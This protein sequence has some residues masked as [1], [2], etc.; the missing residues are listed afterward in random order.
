MNSHRESN[1]RSVALMLLL[2]SSMMHRT[3]AIEIHSNEILLFT[4]EFTPLLIVDAQFFPSPNKT[5]NLC[6]RIKK[7]VR[8]FIIVYVVWNTKSAFKISSESSRERL[9]SAKRVGRNSRWEEEVEK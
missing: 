9:E 1:T 7:S 8:R 3:T 6:T 4:R 5:F 2:A